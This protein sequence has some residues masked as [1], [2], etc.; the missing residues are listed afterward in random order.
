MERERIQGVIDKF[1]EE[2]EKKFQEKMAKNH[3]K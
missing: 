3:L 1:L 2:R